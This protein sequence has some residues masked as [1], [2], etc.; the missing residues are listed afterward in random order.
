MRKHVAAA[1]GTV[2][3]VGAGLPAVA[4]APASAAA[5]TCHPTSH[6]YI[7]HNEKVPV[8]ATPSGR[9]RV[10][11]YVYKDNKVS[12]KLECKM[13]DGTW[14]CIGQCHDPEETLNGRWVYRNYLRG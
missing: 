6:T 14:E 8:H 12:S 2:V 4:A 11:S 5:F 7:V 10:I 1:F 9:G 3:L 13:S